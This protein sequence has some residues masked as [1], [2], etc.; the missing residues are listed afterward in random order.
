MRLGPQAAKFHTKT[1]ALAAIQPCSISSG[2]LCV[3]R[4]ALQLVGLSGLCHRAREEDGSRGAL[5]RAHESGSGRRGVP[6]SFEPVV[7]PSVQVTHTV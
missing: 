4:A 1:G 6:W 3:R 7:D 2:L 5:G